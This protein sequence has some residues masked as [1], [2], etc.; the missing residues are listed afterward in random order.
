MCGEKCKVP[1]GLLVGI[2]AG[3]L[4]FFVSKKISECEGECEP[5]KDKVKRTAAC[6]VEKAQ[7]G[8]QAF[9]KHVEKC[10]DKVEDRIGK[11]HERLKEKEPAEKTEI[12]PDHQ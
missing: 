1:T 10:S 3:V 4:A 5:I 8:F 2:G 6:G 7:G 9:R 12:P 11:L